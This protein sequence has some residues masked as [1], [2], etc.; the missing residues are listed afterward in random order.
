MFGSI[1]FVKNLQSRL[2]K[3][4]PRLQNVFLLDIQKLR[5]AIK[6][7]DHVRY[8]FYTCVD[9]TF[10]ESFCTLLFFFFYTSTYA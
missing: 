9:V 4:E 3:L 1:Y 10:F 5:D 8:K 6:C 7:F 2:D